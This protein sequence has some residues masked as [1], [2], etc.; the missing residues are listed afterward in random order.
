MS[1]VQYGNFDFHKGNTLSLF[2]QTFLLR[3]EFICMDTKSIKVPFDFLSGKH[4][5]SFDTNYY[6]N[7]QQKANFSNYQELV[8]ALNILIP[9]YQYY[10]PFYRL[11]KKA[12]V[13][14]LMA[15]NRIYDR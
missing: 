1:G 9:Y 4:S 8:Q 7:F 15:K 6:H 3:H 2:A 11:N 10:F 14:Q 13:L 5:V 12:M